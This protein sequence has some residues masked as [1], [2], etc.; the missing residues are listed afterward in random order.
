M[1]RRKEAH[2]ARTAW[3]VVTGLVAFMLVL[4][5]CGGSSDD[6]GGGG[7][8]EL[9]KIGKGEG[10]LNLISWAGYVEPEWVKP[11]EAKT[12]CKVNDKI[13]GTSDEMV[14]LMRTGQ[15]DGVSASGNATARLV[16]GGDV[17]P[18]N[19]SLVPNYKTVFA[20]LKNQPYNTFDGVHYGIPHGRGANLLMWNPDDVKP[21][22]TSWDVVLDPKLATKY[23]GRIS[24]Y[25]DP[26]Y[27]ADAAVYLKAHQPDL[28]IE[29]PYE[30]NEEQFEAAV[31][32]L[33]EQRPFV[34]EYWSEA[35][36]QIQAFANGDSQVGTTW[37]YQYFALQEEGKP[38]AASPASQGFLPKEGATGWS[39][40]WMI[41]SEAKHPNCMYM[42]MDWVIEPKVNAE[43]AEFFGEAPA[44]SLAC[45]QTAD[46]NFCAKYHADNPAFWKR[47]YYW[48][49]PLAECGNGEDNCMDYNDWVQAWT[50]IKG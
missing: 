1:R 42:W 2:P 45:D 34:G 31:D 15:Y 13:G 3:F 8:E 12:G 22:P 16:D 47:V 21:T 26:I 43:I 41:S 49:T 48:Q 44:Q 6:N 37:Q 10:E 50:S 35:E 19:V 5:G 32:L 18:V 39:D 27:I 33:K 28:G 11:F 29:N 40:T 38:I 4:A 17:S 30:L 46:K 24:A 36:K 9:Q 25:D 7:G 14:Q 23:K 20:D